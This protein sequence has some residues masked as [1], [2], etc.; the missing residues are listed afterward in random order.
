MFCSS[1]KYLTKNALLKFVHIIFKEKQFGHEI[2]IKRRRRIHCGKDTHVQLFVSQALMRCSARRNLR[3]IH[4]GDTTS[5][6]QLIARYMD[7]DSVI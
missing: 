1:S 2:N 4:L 3:P 6:L 5:N 7:C